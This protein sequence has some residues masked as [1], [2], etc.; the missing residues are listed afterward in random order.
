[1]WPEVSEYSYSY[2]PAPEDRTGKAYNQ[3]AFRHFL[4]IERKRARR[5][6]RSF[7]LLLV[8][9]KTS[10]G[11]P[12]DISPMAAT[13]VFS[14]LGRCVRTVDFI[15]WYRQGRVIGAVLPLGANDL[16][17]IA[18]GVVRTRV[19]DAMRRQLPPEVFDRLDV[20][21]VQIPWRPPCTSA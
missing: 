9:L 1:M 15:G 17:A 21:L 8:T 20:R 13:R 2:G 5:S 19:A 11:V 10:T 14:V 4:A 3:Q 7:S 12:A 16:F 6:G 18:H